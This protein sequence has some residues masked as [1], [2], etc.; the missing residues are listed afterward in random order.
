M[1]LSQISHEPLRIDELVLSNERCVGILGAN[2]S[3]KSLLA[4]LI[5]GEFAP[6][7]GSI[8]DA[9]RKPALISFESLQFEYEQEIAAEDTDF[10]DRIDY[11]STGRELLERSGRCDDEI[12]SAAHAAGLEGLLD[13]GCRQFSSGELR[14]ITLLRETLRMNSEKE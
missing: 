1:R 5:A 8:Q 9:P 10:M 4:S 13:R 12:E 14:R 6:S 2:A 11:G 3:G 7:H